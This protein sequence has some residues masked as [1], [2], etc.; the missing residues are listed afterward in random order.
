MPV[1][2]SLDEGAKDL[3]LYN[4]LRPFVLRLNAFAGALDDTMTAAGAEAKD[5]ADAYYKAVTGAKDRS[6]PQAQAIWEDLKTFYEKSQAENPTPP[7]V[8]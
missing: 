8:V 4:D 3:T 2:V 1:D 5:A 6:N 7:P